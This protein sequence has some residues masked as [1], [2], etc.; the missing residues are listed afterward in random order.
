LDRAQTAEYLGG[1][2]DVVGWGEPV[3]ANNWPA[4]G[5]WYGNE[6]DDTAD[7]S[8]RRPKSSFHVRKTV[9][10]Y[11]YSQSG[12]YRICPPNSNS[13]IAASFVLFQS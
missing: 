12:D 1:L 5:R 11:D 10:A 2:S 3:R 13:F 8:A 6:P 9:K 4:D 7:I